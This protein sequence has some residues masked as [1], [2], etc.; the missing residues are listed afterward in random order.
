MDDKQNIIF[1][2]T[3]NSCRSQIAEAFLRKYAGDRFNVYSA[4]LKPKEIHPLTRRVMAEIGMNLEGH[5]SKDVM[6][7][8]GKVLPRYVIVVCEQ[9]EKT[10]P[11]V[12]PSTVRRRFW[13]FED[14]AAFDGTEDEKLEKFSRVRDQIEARILKWLE[15]L[16]LVEQ[17]P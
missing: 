17:E 16:D 5:Y 1:L 9:A 15:Q 7:L 8:S 11:Y 4:G 10:C 2:C 3:S 12:W 13:P 6:E 14:P